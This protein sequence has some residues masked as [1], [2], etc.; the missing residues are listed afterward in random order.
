[1][2]NKR[3]SVD[4]DDLVKEYLSGK[5]ITQLKRQFGIGAITV[6]GIL[7]RNGVSI[8]PARVSATRIDVPVEEIVARY[9]SGE[10]IKSLSDFYS[11]SRVVITKRLIECGVNRRDR[12][13]AMYQRM[14]QTSPEERMRLVH[15]AHAAIQGTKQTF[16]EKRKRAL[17]VQNRLTNVSASETWLADELRAKGYDAIQQFAVGTYNCDV[18]VHPVAVEIFGG[19][20]HWYGR[21]KARAIERLHYFLDHGWHVLIITTYGRIP[22]TGETTEYVASFIEETRR[23]P[24]ASRQYR[25]IRGAGEILAAGSADDDQFSIEPSFTCGR[26]SLGQY[27]RAPR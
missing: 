26:N 12:S 4:A 19:G 16:S 5:N 22:L 2:S 25:V 15:S 17:T 11:V 21:H 10:S 8:R 27:T 7:D 14:S 9:Q 6:L 1:M 24:T 23:D 20:W 13:A 18:A 3:N